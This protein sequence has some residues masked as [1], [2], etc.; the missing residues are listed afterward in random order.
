MACA[1]R[2]D[3]AHAEGAKC[4]ARFCHAIMPRYRLAPRAASFEVALSRL[5]HVLVL[6]PRRRMVLALV[7]ERA[8]SSTIT[9]RSTST[10][11][12]GKTSIETPK[13]SNTTTSNAASHAWAL[14]T[15]SHSISEEIRL[16][17][18]F[19]VRH[20]L[21]GFDQ[22]LGCRC[23]LRIEFNLDRCITE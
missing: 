5:F 2:T 8:F 14:C 18:F 15:L 22:T 23:R 20:A 13:H 7:I 9:S 4:P 11:K 19:M 12:P 16:R 3:Q 1:K 21:F 10:N 17:A 6:N